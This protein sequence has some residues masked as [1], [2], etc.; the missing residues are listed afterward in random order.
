MTIDRSVGG[1]AAQKMR[2]MSPCFFVFFFAHMHFLRVE[3]LQCLTETK[4]GEYK[5][6]TQISPGKFCRSK[7]RGKLLKCQQT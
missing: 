4:K 5:K 2:A 3:S 6:R 1:K 7:S